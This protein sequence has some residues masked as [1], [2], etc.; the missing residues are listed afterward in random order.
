MNLSTLD[1]RPRA[2]AAGVHLL[3]SVAIAIAAAA[4]VFMLWYPWPYR[5][6][7][8]GQGLFLLMIS[9]DL[10]LGPLLTFAVFDRR[11]PRTALRR[12]LTVIGLLQLSALIYGVHTVYAARPVALIFEVDR[13]RVISA[14]DV[15]LPELP[16][17]LEPYRRLPLTGPRLLGARAAK[18]GEERGDAL[19]KGFEGI[20]IGQRPTFWEPYDQYKDRAL[21]RSR[22]LEVLLQR[23]PVAWAEIEPILS[24]LGRA[25]GEVR[26][27]PL[28]ARQQWVVL[29]DKTGEVIGFAPF[30]GFF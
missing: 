21:A 24:N 8:G 15:H 11:K 16:K 7:S 19:S 22:P 29:L 3:I 23:Y 6:I 18:P 9:V 14:V 26:F 27:L 1:L 25:K 5:V 17:A 28:M 10:A 2:F 20:D 30:D 12:D 4:L 13:F